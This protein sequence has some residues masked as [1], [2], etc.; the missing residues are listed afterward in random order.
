MDAMVR[1]GSWGP[2]TAG[3]RTAVVGSVAAGVV[4]GMWTMAAEAAVGEGFWA[5]MVYIAA[6]VLRGL[7]AVGSRPGFLLIPV[8]VGLMGHMMNSAVLGVVFSRLLAGLART[9]ARTVGLGIAYGVAVFAVMWYAVL[10]LVDPVMLR[11]A[12]WAFLVGHVL[13]GAGLGVA[14]LVA[15]R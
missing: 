9:P 7:Q 5:P 8:I 14:A 13:Y 12:G 15:R 3:T 10:P 1:A 6:T 11:L 4:M 2:G